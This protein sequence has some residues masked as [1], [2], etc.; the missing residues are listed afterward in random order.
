VAVR[1]GEETGRGQRHYVAEGL[2]A[3]LFRVCGAPSMSGTNLA[4]ARRLS[5]EVTD[6][7]Q[8]TILYVESPNDLVPQIALRFLAKTPYSVCA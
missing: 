3:A 5:C 6:P 7:Y 4:T 1:S 2:I 8:V